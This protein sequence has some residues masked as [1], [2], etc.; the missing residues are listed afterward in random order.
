MP[1]GLLADVLDAEWHSAG[2][3][4][5]KPLRQ[6]SSFVVC[7][8]DP[9]PKAITGLA[10]ACL[11]SGGDCTEPA[12]FVKLRE[13]SK[14]VDKTVEDALRE[15]TKFRKIFQRRVNDY[16][17]AEL[18]EKESKF[19][20]V[21][22]PDGPFAPGGSYLY[23]MRRWVA[24][25]HKL[26]RV[27]FDGT[28]GCSS[29]IDY[30]RDHPED[31]LT[32]DGFHG[33]AGSRV[34]DEFRQACEVGKSRAPVPNNEPVWCSERNGLCEQKSMKQWWHDAH[35]QQID[36]AKGEA[37]P[38]VDD[39]S[40]YD[41]LSDACNWVSYHR[42]SSAELD[43]YQRQLQKI[44]EVDKEQYCS[45]KWVEG[46]CESKPKHYFDECHLANGQMCKRGIVNPGTD[47]DGTANWKEE[48]PEKPLA[49]QQSAPEPLCALLLS[50]AAR[51]SG[52]RLHGAP[53]KTEQQRLGR[54][55]SAEKPC[56][57]SR[58]ARQDA[59]PADGIGAF[60]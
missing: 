38:W 25:I 54:R 44:V 27:C 52:G 19:L 57:P 55:R 43:R 22:G 59:L 28:G 45:P 42:P 56:R 53:P 58:R 7:P 35:I 51:S 30:L 36:P 32:A 12:E 8:N 23:A 10:P 3:A 20:D 11:D 26:K 4:V 17:Y 1:S 21:Y 24:A 29:L 49:Q 39:R 50:A 15:A 46:Y 14:A 18:A 60:L 13:F 2:G 34:Y 37:E 48:F 33:R 5:A 41:D 6:P 16:K 40:E 9:K 31:D 47:L